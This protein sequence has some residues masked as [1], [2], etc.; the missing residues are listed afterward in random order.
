MTKVTNLSKAIEIVKAS[1]SKAEALE[2]MVADLGVS[3]SNAFVYYTKPTKGVAKP[4]KAAHNI[5]PSAPKLTTPAR[6]LISKP[7]AA[8]AKT[9]P[10][11][12][13]AAKSKA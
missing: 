6:S 9:V 5:M 11:L 2:K 8:M 1:A 3:R 7:K 10:A 4:A 13:V 12:R